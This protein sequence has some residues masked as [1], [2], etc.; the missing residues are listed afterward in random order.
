[1]KCLRM[2]LRPWNIRVVNVNPSFMKTAW[3]PKWLD[4]FKQQYRE[5]DPELKQQYSEEHVSKNANVVLYFQ[6]VCHCCDVTAEL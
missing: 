6:E 2:E 5:A 4:A 3:V 1:M